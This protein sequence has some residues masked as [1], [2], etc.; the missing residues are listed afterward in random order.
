M[1]Y[2]FY[3]IYVTVCCCPWKREAYEA[4]FEGK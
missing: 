3:I 2:F 4:D 1:V